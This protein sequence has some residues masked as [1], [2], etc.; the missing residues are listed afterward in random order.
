MTF[1]ETNLVGN[2]YFAQYLHWQGHCRE[3]FLAEHAPSVVESLKTGELALATVSC[4]MDFYKE[5][6]ALDE[7]D[8]LMSLRDKG[9]GRITMHFEFRRDG[10]LVATGTQVVACLCRED[11]VHPVDIPAELDDALSAYAPAPKK[12]V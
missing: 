11:G 1:D 12:L 9:G 5:C 3:R 4:S 10:E 2:V 6:F 7:I 8:V